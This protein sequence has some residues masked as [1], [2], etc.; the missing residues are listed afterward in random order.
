[1][2]DLHIDLDISDARIEAFLSENNA[3]EQDENKH[4]S[5]DVVRRNALQSFNDMQACPGSGK[6]TLVASKLVIL[7]KEWH[8]K[9]Q[10]LCVLTHT[11]VACYEILSRLGAH[12]SGVKLTSYPHFIGTIQE[13]TNKYLG[14]PYIRSNGLPVSRIDDDV[15]ERYM[16]GIA[17]RGTLTYLEQ[18]RASLFSLKIDH[19]TGE[20]N[21]PGFTSASQSNSYKDLQRV[22]RNRLNRGLFFYSEMYHFAKQAIAENKVLSEALRNRFPIVI[23]DEMQDTQQFQ[24]ELIN[25]IFQHD[26][27]KLQRFGDPDQ[28]IFDNMGGGEPN[29]SFNSKEGLA[30]VSHTHRFTRDIASKVKGLSI[31][32]IGVIT[33]RDVPQEPLPHSVFIFDDLTKVDVIEQFSKLVAQ[34]DPDEK[35]AAVKAVGATEGEGGHISA[36]WDGFDKNRSPKGPKPQTLFEIVSRD[37]RRCDRHSQKQ[38]KFL[39]QGVLDLLRISQTTDS[40]HDPARYF[41]ASS[42]KSWLIEVARYNEFRALITSWIFN[43]PPDETEWS[44]QVSKLRALLAVTSTSEDTNSFLSFSDQALAEGEESSILNMYIA[45]NGRQIE[46]GTIHSIKGETHDAT[47]VLETKNHQNDLEQLL[48][49]ISGIEHGAISGVRK[50]RFARLLYVATT[51]PRHLLCLAI[52]SENVSDAQEQALSDN[53]WDIKRLTPKVGS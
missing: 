3:K 38:Y 6:T 49:H 23:L 14:L 4:L 11:N 26:N 12:P 44:S 21:I 13:F 39:V 53:G 20:I 52:H 19:V 51:R 10:G 29:Q 22:F 8:A 1:M 25:S 42:L 45:A 30:V 7:A 40:R 47:L 35:W 5:F 16:R 9:H 15:C 18:K 33:A 24:D 27:V 46:V 37:W 43:G 34:C 28:A 36:Y 31:R 17:A 32:Q 50:V 2:P 48:D 41:T